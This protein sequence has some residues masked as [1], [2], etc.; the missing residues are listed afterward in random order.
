MFKNILVIGAFLASLALSYYLG[1]SN[2][3]I[4]YV[5]KEV[6]VI[7]YEKVQACNLLARPNLGDD[8][9][10]RLFDTGQL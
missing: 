6:E 3:K 5:T 4:Q 8:D 1:A 10:S 7:K 2:A 9:I